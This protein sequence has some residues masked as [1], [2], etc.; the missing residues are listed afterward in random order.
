ME[1]SRAVIEIQTEQAQYTLAASEIN[2][3]GISGQIGERVNLSDIK[4]QIQIGKTD[5]Q[6][7]AEVEGKAKEKG[8]TLITSPVDFHISAQYGDQTVTVERF[9]SYVERKIAIPEGVDASRITT[10]VVVKNDG[11]FYHVPTKVVE[12]QGKQYAVINSLSNST[13]T[14]IWNQ[15]EFEDVK[16]HW[17]RVDINDMGSRLIIN[18]MTEQTFAPE[19]DVTR[20]EFAA[21]LIRALGLQ[22]RKEANP[23]VD[24][25]EEAW[26]HNDVVT[27]YQNKFLSGYGDGTFRPNDRIKREEAIA[28]IF[29]AASTAKL[30]TTISAEE[31]GSALSQ[32]ADKDQISD[33]AKEAMGMSIQNGIVG[34]FDGKLHPR[35][36]MKRAEAATM[37]RRLLMKANLI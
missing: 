7:V 6:K 28:M 19:L 4:I 5:G 37:I 29:N 1:L 11:S 33:W 16:D 9:N 24:V 12:V 20:A 14:V 18:G 23:F 36:Y 15:K 32:F 35:F 25:R 22:V 8:Y 34:G 10:G 21:M 2:I 13:Y 17:G 26:Y 27:A 30:N 31:I 3:D